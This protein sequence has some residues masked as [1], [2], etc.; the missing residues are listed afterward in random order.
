MNLQKGLNRIFILLGLVAAVFGCMFGGTYAV[1]HWEPSPQE[2]F[3]SINWNDQENINKY[4]LTAKNKNEEETKENARRKKIKPDKRNLLS[5]FVFET[6]TTEDL[7]NFK[8]SPP[9]Y[10][11]YVFRETFPNALKTPAYKVWIGVV[12]GALLAFCICYGGL[13][14]I[15]L[16]IKWIISGFKDK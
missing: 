10:N 9:Q 16:V 15:R 5:R 12:L 8:K 7:P 2:A 3:Q 11:E 6:V 4:Y 13:H 14:S 1:S